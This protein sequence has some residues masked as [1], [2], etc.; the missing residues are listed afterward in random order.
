MKKLA[1]IF[2]QLAL[3]PQVCCQVPVGTWSDHLMYGTAARLAVTPGKV[4][5]STG[6]SLLV[7]DREYEELSKLSKVNGLSETGI[8]DISWSEEYKTLAVGYNSA[9]IDLVSGNSVFYITD[10]KNKQIETV[11]RINRIRSE[12]RYTYVAVAFG[13][14]VIDLAGK[15]IRDTWHPGPGS[16]YNEVF[17]VAFGNGEV[18]AATAS[19]LWKAPAS[20]DG[21]AYFANWT[22]VAEMP[23]P[24]SKCNHLAYSG[25]TLY[26]N[27][28]SQD[29]DGDKVYTLASGLTLFSGGGG[30]SNVSIDPAPEGFTITSPGLVRYYRSDGTLSRSISSYGWGS[31]AMS[32]GVVDGPD[33]WIA[34]LN[35]G[36]IR[37]KM[38][39]QFEAL[40]LPGPVANSSSGIISAGGRTVICAGGN[41]NSWGALGNTFL[42]SVAS[43]N[44]FE[45]V[46]Q[47]GFHDAERSCFDPEDNSH[48]F[49]SS[50]GDG[51]FECRGR[52][53][54]RHYDQT[55]SPLQAGSG[56]GVKVCGLATDRF[57]NL[58]M[59]V[60][61]VSGSIRI[62]KPDGSWISYPLNI[63]APVIGDILQA[64]NG[65]KWILLPGSNGLFILDD[66]GTPEVFTDDNY[67]KIIVRDSEGNVMSGVFSIAEDSEGNIWVGSDQGPVVYY[68][69]SQGLGADIT[70]FRI[71]VPRNDGSGLADYL[72]GTE[73]ITA[74][75]V[76]GAGRKWIGT[77]NS[78][79]YLLSADGT[80][81]LKNYNSANSPMLSD[82]ITSVA[83]DNLT[84]EVWFGTSRGI[85][86]LREIATAGGD[87]F[88]KVYSFPNPVRETFTGNVTITGLMK[89]T[90]IKI[91]DIG[92]NLVYE[93]RSEGGQASWDLSN[94]TGNRVATGVYLVFCASSDG[95]QSC[96][97]KILVIGR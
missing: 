87:R 9:G 29:Q 10:I 49:I 64:G 40:A 50:W 22:L 31:P 62:L 24:F 19:G 81:V 66:N 3:I 11:K 91:T 45:A 61:G 34:D 30:T 46:V 56:G 23:D 57:R 36:L 72:L 4:F 86:S 15:E 90:D 95:S 54:V 75:S 65:L 79:A 67:K 26:I 37:G 16:E 17:D 70:G 44:S 25:S 28:P 94:Y 80:K 63:G 38:M 97:T 83:V 53:V 8:S 93:T 82:H 51:L 96:V 77:L 69:N 1:V 35:S 92:G 7:F 48:F 88:G 89:D 71:K 2:F 52:S 76:D 84:G 39:N 20:G 33:I 21:L 74:L 27:V 58:W 85:L 14:V 5:A 78:G 18:Y 60:S 43:G 73:T 68:Q 12:G 32:Q 55:N 41:S 42:A 6:E 47:N 13:I 59:T